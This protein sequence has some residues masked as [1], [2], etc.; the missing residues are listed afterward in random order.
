MSFNLQFRQGVD[1]LYHSSYVVPISGASGALVMNVKS[2]ASYQAFKGK[3]IYTVNFEDTNII[4]GVA[5]DNNGFYIYRADLSKD[6]FEKL[7]NIN[8]LS[9]N[10][11][12]W[13]QGS[14]DYDIENKK[15]YI[16]G[17]KDDKP[18]FH[19][20]SLG[21]QFAEGFQLAAPQY[22]VHVIDGAP[23]GMEVPGDL[24]IPQGTS[25]YDPQHKT[26]YATG[27][28][29]PDYGPDDL[30]GNEVFGII[31]L[32]YDAG[33][34]TFDRFVPLG[35]ENFVST[36][37]FDPASGRFFARREL[38]DSSIEIVSVDIDGNVYSLGTAVGNVFTGSDGSD[39][40]LGLGG[41]DVAIGGPGDDYLEGGVGNDKLVG[42]D[43][44]QNTSSSSAKAPASPAGGVDRL[45][46]GPGRDKL[47]GGPDADHFVFD[48]KPGKKNF[49]RIKDFEPG[50]DKID[51]VSDRFK[52]IGHRLT[53]GEFLGNSKYAKDKND[54]ILLKDGKIYYDPD[55]SGDHKAKIFAKIANGIELDHHDFL[56][57]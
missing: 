56:V 3:D 41:D 37:I 8:N 40:W 39:F 49:D 53:K 15:L 4:I 36:L 17:T 26:A 43:P 25:T 19:V 30:L 32:R 35:S 38:S 31:S 48:V 13:Q 23:V 5:Q 34:F 2:G 16:S 22:E 57:A 42:D 10:T 50:F 7:Y 6:K 45:V 52:A 44:I 21:K 46:G 11:Y 54:K 12:T 24:S 1:A 14:Y 51:L 55:G 29:N 9:S 27:Y 18:G 47:I 33:S 20:F 28:Y